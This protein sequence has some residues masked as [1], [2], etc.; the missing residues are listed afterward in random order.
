MPTRRHSRHGYALKRVWR[1]VFDRRFIP[2]LLLVGGVLFLVGAGTVLWWS[3]DLPDPEKV[4]ASRLV[5]ST[6]IYDSTGTHLLYEIGESRRTRVSLADISPLLINATLAVEDDQFYEHHGLDFFGILRGVVLKPLTGERAQGGSTIT[7]QLI[8]NS[9]LTP[10][11]TVQR[12]VK[13]AVLALE[14]EQR[15]EKDTILEMYLNSIPYGNRS[16]GVEA[17]AQTFFGTSAKNVS[18]AQASMLAALPKAPTYYS[19]Y[20]SHY[21]DLKF[22]QEHIVNRM[23]H[24]NMISTEEAE[25]AKKEELQLLPPRES[26]QAPHFVFYVKELLEE[27][28]GQ[29]VVEEGGLRVT[30]TLDMRL[31]LI[32]EEVLKD[33]QERLKALGASNGAIV[34][35]NPG[36][37]DILAMAGSLDYFN[38][39]IDGN[40]NVAVRHRSPGS[41]IKPFIYAAAF[42]KG[43]TPS[44]ILVDAET[45]FGQD[46]RPKNYDL[47]Q[48]GPVTMRSALANSINIPAVQTLYLVGVKEATDLAQK[49][50]MTSLHD[51]DRYGLSLVLGG[52]EVRLL[53]IASAYG[54]FA[55]EGSRYPTRPI[56]KVEDASEVLFDIT[57]ESPGGEAALNP[58]TARLITDVLADNNA[59]A[60][61]FGTG[62][63]LQLGSRPVAAKTGTTQDFRDGWTLGFTPSLVAGVWVGNNDNSPMG[64]GAAGANSAAQIW[65]AF[66]RRALEG[67][68]I[69]QFTRPEPQQNLPHA[70][71]R[72]ELPEVKGKWIEETKTLYTLECPIAEGQPRTFKELHSIL[73]YVRRTNPLGPP[74]A[75]AESD[76]QFRSWEA[77]VATWRDKHNTEA[78]D[79]SEEPFYTDSLPEPSCN[80]GSEDELPQVKIVE[81]NSTVLRESP[82]IVKVEVDSPHPLREV[83]FLL[84]KQEIARRG[85]GDNHSASFSFPGNFS[86]RKTLQVLAITEDNLIGQA[87]RTFIINPDDSAPEVTLH[88]PLNNTKLKP[89][90]FPQTI[91]VTAKD[92]NGIESV[93]VLYT[94]DGQ[95]GARRI[96]RTSTVAPTAPNRY[97][98]AW[99]DSPGP[100]TYQVYAVAYDKTGNFTE[101]S[102][103]TVVIE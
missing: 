24:L 50:G 83:R 39:E 96:A 55:A 18:L 68:P 62:S 37:G 16:Y 31:Q 81:P 26:I 22:R 33:A 51:P 52:G 6:K 89:T 35:I 20:G 10:E 5:E 34:A 88:T 45:D 70:V 29:R 99:D 75:S 79:T 3:R 71:L 36:T 2:R 73:Y 17:A 87:H 43:F 95:D 23:A 19:P 65:N 59:R 63:Y 8:K 60:I 97:E 93:D 94:K 12:K 78:K 53:D 30:T 84:D 14:L 77:A 66:M 82:V 101:S 49:M 67:T 86:G 4:E 58:Q 92:S 91:K 90:D 32:A 38:E 21:E 103:H 25:A 11:R 15:F 80:I 56:L 1:A 27:E 64:K 7:Q 44:T 69:E 74:P 98:V 54:V 76:P 72:G 47:G 40:V 102:R 46:Y 9:L 57:E 42:D 61:V 100:G 28:Y 13:E 41:S 85:P 48:R